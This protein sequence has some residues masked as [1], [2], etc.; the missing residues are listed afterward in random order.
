MGKETAPKI[1]TIKFTG[2]EK[3]IIA[4]AVESDFFKILANK[5]RPQR[6]T[7]IALTLLN[8]GQSSEDLQYFRGMSYENDWLIKELKRV[9]DEYNKSNLDAD[10]DGVDAY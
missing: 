3:E 7:K 1:G 8:L 5:L 6:Q 4:I 9:A 2:K 10:T